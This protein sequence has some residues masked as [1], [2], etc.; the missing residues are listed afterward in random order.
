VSR[1]NDLIRQLRSKDQALAD[2]I[3]REVAAL[4]DRRAFGLNFERHVPE[5]VELPGRRVRRGDK[6]RVLPPR[7]TA[8]TKAHDRVWLVGAVEDSDGGRVA[9]LESLDGEDATSAAAPDLVVVAEF[10]DPIY[11]GLV[12]TG[13][14]ERGGDKPFHTVI[15]GENYYALQALLFTHRARVDCIYIDPPY[16]TGAPDWKYNNHYVEEDD[17]YRHSKWLAFMERRLL[18]ARELLNPEGSVLI[19]TIDNNEGSRLGLLLEQTFPDA[20]INMVT[21]VINPRGKYRANEFAR[22]EEYIF[23]LLFG[24]AVVAGEPDPDYAEGEMVPWR[25]FRRSD[26]SSARGTGKG[27]PAQFYPIYVDGAGRAV[28]IGDALPHGVPRSTAPTRPGCEGVFPIRDDGTEMNWGLSAPSAR[29][30]LKRGYIRVGRRTVGKPQAYEVSYLLAGRIEDIESGRAV[31]VGENP[32]GSVIARYETSKLRMPTSTWNRPSHNA[33][34]H[35]TELLKTLLGGKLFPYPKSLYAVEDALR[36]FVGDKPDALV[37]DFFSGSGTT[38][39]ATMRLNKQDGGRRRSVMITNNEVSAEEEAALR[40]RGL[41]P[42]DAEWECLGICEF[43]TKPRLAAAITGH[44]PA[45]RP[46]TGSYRFIDEFPISD[47]LEENVEFFKLT[48]QAPLRV[49]S[50]REFGR[51]A[52]LLWMRAG[53][54]GRRI[55]DLSKGWEVA[56]AYGVLADLDCV[57]QFLDALAAELGA[58]IVFILTE[59]DRLFESVVRELPEHVEP[60]RLYDAYLRNFE[61]ESARAAR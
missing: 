56:D 2:D 42:G 29:N 39:H 40:K 12:S 59:E 4:A 20:R 61:I 25:T 16:N 26:L 13:K 60:V 8:P 1:L 11:P 48:Y 30:L 24:R 35:G 27:G 47:G 50:N 36:L 3:E 38:A 14:V 23:F 31:V 44:T 34:V 6:V 21:S 52:P 10:R 37:V 53:S 18:L 22:C 51:V 7:G 32:D 55:D 58:E 43:I 49:S 15:N 54:R 5:A 46:V 33:E 57:D 17:L 45:G 41:R 9:A 19:V 28:E